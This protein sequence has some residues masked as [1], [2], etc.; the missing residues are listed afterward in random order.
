M[1]TKEF[2]DTLFACFLLFSLGFCM[3]YF[4][5]RFDNKKK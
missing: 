2:C 3:G 5:K 4:V 1:T